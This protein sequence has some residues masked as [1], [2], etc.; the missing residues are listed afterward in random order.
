M[1][2]VRGHIQGP[3]GHAT[4]KFG[5]R[6]PLPKGPWAMTGPMQVL[7]RGALLEGVHRRPETIKPNSAELASPGGADTAVHDQVVALGKKVED[8]LTEDEVATV[9]PHVHIC[10]RLDAREAAISV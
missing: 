10:N 2:R 8:L 3:Y 5:T 7:Q 6:R 9:D 1:R 4:R